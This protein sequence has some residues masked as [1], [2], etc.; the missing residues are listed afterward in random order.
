MLVPVIFEDKDILVIDKP[1][2]ISVVGEE[3]GDSITIKDWVKDKYNYISPKGGAEDEFEQRLGIVHRLDKET[4]GI[5]LVAKNKEVFQYLKG[6]F[7]FRRIKKEY[8]ALVYG[9]VND[10]RFEVSASI[11]RDRNTGT[12]YTLDKDGRGSSTEFKVIRRMT[13]QSCLGGTALMT[14]LNAYPKTGRTHQI[15]VHLKALGHPVVND[16]KYASRALLRLSKGMFTRMMLHAK[17]VSFTDWNGKKRVFE[18]SLSLSDYF[19]F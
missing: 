15:R 14:Y 13:Q 17:S 16:A 4:S 8:Q 2:G 11:S 10:E 3:G 9:N 19:K 6:L 7:K 5:L 1:L 12:T 18:S